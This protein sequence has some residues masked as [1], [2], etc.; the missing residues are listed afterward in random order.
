MPSISNDITTA[1][2]HQSGKLKEEAARR[3]SKGTPSSYIAPVVTLSA[4]LRCGVGLPDRKLSHV[5]IRTS[6][7]TSA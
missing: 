3:N 1:T 2:N 4:L 7:H 6:D 5:D